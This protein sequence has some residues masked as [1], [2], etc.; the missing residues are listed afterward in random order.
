[1]KKHYG[2]LVAGLMA[3][4]LVFAVAASALNFF[5]NDAAR[6]GLS[7]ALA[8]GIPVVLFLAWFATSRGFREYA[9]SLD[10]RLLTLLHTW[11]IG[12]TTFLVLSAYGILPGMFAQPAGWGDVFIGATAPLVAF[13]LT[14]PRHKSTFMAWQVLGLIDLVM[15]VTLGTTAGFIHPHGVPTAAMT[16]L[17]LSVVPTFL[18]PLLLMVHIVLIAQARRWVGGESLPG[19]TPVLLAA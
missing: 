16:V 14:S 2:K 10:P 7:V 13:Y 17:P 6:I 3:I 5:K 15:A 19:S 9:V 8:A 11:R 18:V 4:W 12:G 1:M